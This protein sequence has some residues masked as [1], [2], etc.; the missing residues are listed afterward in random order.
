MQR[1]HGHT[2]TVACCN[3]VLELV[4]RKGR[5]ECFEL[6]PGRILDSV[7]QDSVAALFF[8]DPAL[9]A[10]AEAVL[11]RYICRSGRLGGDQL[12]HEAL[13]HDDA[14]AA[15]GKEAALGALVWRSQIMRL[16]SVELAE[17]AEQRVPDKVDVRLEED[18]PLS[19][20]VRDIRLVDHGQVLEAVELE[21]ALLLLDRLALG[22]G[23]LLLDIR[24]EV[25][26]L[27]LVALGQL[28][29]DVNHM[30][31]SQAL[32]AVADNQQVGDAAGNRAEMGLGLGR[33]AGRHF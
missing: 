7:G 1:E 20:R 26:V 25:E 12:L 28:G 17:Q 10:H 6:V 19:A 24:L 32:V 21:G 15:I 18:E 33:L 31:V 2:P 16:R 22:V 3:D 11:S 14:G 23:L 13:G 5:V 27:G 4:A 8:L 9:E 30:T 29:E